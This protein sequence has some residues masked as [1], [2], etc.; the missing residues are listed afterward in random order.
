MPS[1]V[2]RLG[3]LSAA[4]AAAPTYAACPPPPA[5][6]PDIRALGYYTDKAGSVIDPVLQQQNKDATAPLDRYAADVARMSDDYLRT[7]DPAAA[8]CTLSW[9]GAWADDGAML[10]QMIRVNNDQSF[11][12]RQWMLDAVAMAYL[13]VHDQANP[14]QRA[15]IDPWLQK[16]A[17]ANLAYW[18]NP[19]RRR[20][21]HYYWG[22]L[23]VLAT[24]LATDD[25]ALWEAGHAAF[26]KG[27][28]DIQYDGSLPLEMA[29]GQRA[30]HYHDYALAPLVMMA[31]LARLHGQDGYASGDHAIDRLARRVIEGS[32]DPAWFNEHTG[33]AQLP[34]QASGWV[35]FYRLRSPDGGLFDA[36]H[37]RGPFH[38]PRLG[39]DLTLMATH[40]IVRA[41]L[42]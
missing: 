24:G 37:A 27:I 9:L 25:E 29:R 18:D 3:L 13:K 20:N 17:R 22:A 10:G 35:E 31:E 34:L 21:N 32:K 15:H 6:H 38:S 1:L 2:L 41:P 42:R 33:V 30:L 19:K 8:Q 5:G 36:A 26:Q 39:G 12:M 16:L 40:G 23:G 28:D 4:L 7:G 11:Y 14:Q